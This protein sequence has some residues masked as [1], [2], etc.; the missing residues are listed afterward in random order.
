MQAAE[1]IVAV[2]TQMPDE[3]LHEAQRGLA[4]SAML[5]DKVVE[6]LAPCLGTRRHAEPQQPQQPS[7]R[8]DK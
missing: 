4:M 3:L 5:V 8:A 7:P 2:H 6:N 1:F